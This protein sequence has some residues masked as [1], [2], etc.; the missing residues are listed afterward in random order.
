[1]IPTLRE[2]PE[3]GSGECRTIDVASPAVLAHVMRSDRG[4]LLFL[5]NLGRDDVVVDLDPQ[6]DAEGDPVEVFGDRA[7]PAAGADLRGLELAGL[8]YRWLRLRRVA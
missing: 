2:C 5:H 8:G 6:P 4:T 3:V 1:M 7:Y